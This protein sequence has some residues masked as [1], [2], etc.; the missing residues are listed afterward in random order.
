[1]AVSDSQT[2]HVS[3]VEAALLD[4]ELFMK[5]QAPERAI[6]RLK[7]AL[8]VNTRSIKLRERL[9]EVCA[10]QKH[11]EEAANA[12]ILTP[13]TTVCSKPNSSTRASTSQVDSKPFAAPGVLI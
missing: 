13:P 12:K 3:E 10:A 11:T 5:Y 8:E 6:K 2:E 7:T 1:M 4:A 9:R